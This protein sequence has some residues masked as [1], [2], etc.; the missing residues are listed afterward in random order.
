MK[1]PK[2]TKVYTGS[3]CTLHFKRSFSK[4][5]KNHVKDSVHGTYIKIGFFVVSTCV[6]KAQANKNRK[7][8]VDIV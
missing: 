6:G 8:T 2:Y 3:F 1:N 4:I 7:T 5:S